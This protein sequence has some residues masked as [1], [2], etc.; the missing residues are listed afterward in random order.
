MTCD[1]I[2]SG[3]NLECTADETVDPTRVAALHE[4]NRAVAC[5]MADVSEEFGTVCYEVGELCAAA[6]IDPDTVRPY[7]RD[8]VLPKTAPAPVLTP[9][10]HHDHIHI[11]SGVEQVGWMG[12]TGRVYALDDETGIRTEPGGFSP[13]YQAR[14]ETCGHQ[15]REAEEAEQIPTLMLPGAVLTAL[16]AVME[17]AD[18]DTHKMLEGDE[19]GVDQY[20]ALV[21]QFTRAYGAAIRS[22][23]PS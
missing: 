13:L 20:P 16:K 14:D 4:A 18:Y 22:G 5:Q 2:E 3:C 23:S 12:Q 15:I 6:G 17:R 8:D 1:P 9:H 7:V 19:S 10:V 21:E 11:P